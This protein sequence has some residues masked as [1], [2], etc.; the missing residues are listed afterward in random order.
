MA[1]F[2]ITTSGTVA[3]VTLEEFELVLTH[4]QTIDLLAENFTYSEIT[5]N[6]Q[7]QEAIDAGEIIATNESAATITNVTLEKV[8]LASSSGIADTDALA[9]GSTNLYFT[10]LRARAAA[11][12]N[13]TAGT[14]TDQAASVA[15]V[16]S[17]V[18]AEIDAL[19]G[20]AGAAYDTLIELQN[21][22]QSNDTDLASLLTA[23]GN[24]LDSSA[25]SAFGLTLI[26]D[27]DAD[28]ARTTLGLGTAATSDTTDFATAAQGTLAST[29]TQPGA[30]ISTLTND[31]G[32]VDAAAAA[33]AAPVQ[34]VNGSS[35][36]VVLDT[37]NIA[38]NTNLYYT[39]A[40]V[41]ANT[42]VTA[43]T[44]KI[45]ADGS[46]D[47][48]SDVDVTTTAP[49][50]GDILEF[51][52]TNW[53]PSQRVYGTEFNL[54][55]DAAV[56]ET[57]NGVTT[58]QDKISDTTTA[59]P[60]GKYKI[61]VSYIW[62]H[63]GT[64]ADFEGVLLFDGNALGTN[65]SGLIHK[66]EPKDAAG[67]FSNTGSSQAHAYTKV[68]FIDVAVAGTK[69]VLLQYRTDNTSQTSSIWDASIEIIRV[70]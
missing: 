10:D 19:K 18:T 36:T 23:V 38:E 35:G 7:L 50:S 17:L 63:N 11:V 54:F 3:S 62:N 41:S 24:K 43:N 46:I 69:S 56:S 27:A 13:S 26:D 57:P 52:G 66:Q 39:E 30:N 28:T 8:S 44:A 31:S 42:D 49:I 47:S 61:T 53:T 21:E 33:S 14:E 59:L 48:H 25:V 15:A 60:V 45:S 58:F 20:G 6:I 68:Y 2:N 16:K 9:E 12:V 55:E 51:D 64:T 22:I 5:D 29:A 67:N 34:S 37:S 1:Q 40:R 70:S 4:P 32:F 65:T